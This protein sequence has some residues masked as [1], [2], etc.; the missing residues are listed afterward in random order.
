MA[1]NLV[2]DGRTITVPAPTGGAVSGV[3][4]LLGGLLLVPI[5][6]ADEGDPVACATEGVFTLPKLSTDDMSTQGVP[7]FWNDSNA[8]VQLTGAAT[9]VRVGS[10]FAAAGAATTTVQVRLNGTAVPAES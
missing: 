9:T 4:F 10:V 6:S 3:P 5:T 7:V 1:Q 8:E 2:A